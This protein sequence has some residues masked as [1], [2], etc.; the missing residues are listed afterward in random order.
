MKKTRKFYS[1]VQSEGGEGAHPGMNH[2]DRIGGEARRPPDDDG[3]L[4]AAGDGNCAAQPCLVRE[5]DL[6]ADL[7]GLSLSDHHR[8]WMSYE[9]WPGGYR[10]RWIPFCVGALED[11]LASFGKPETFNTDE[12]SQ[13]ISNAFTVV[14]R[15]AEIKMRM[16]GWGRLDGQCLNRAAMVL[17]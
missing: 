3:G 16:D 13:F 7:A 14:L 9:Y 15:A 8:D 17:Y 12:G 4:Q 1:E 6:S 10:T 2:L 11:A 5:C